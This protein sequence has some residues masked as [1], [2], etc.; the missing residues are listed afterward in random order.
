MQIRFGIFA[1]GLLALSALMMA[2]QSAHA[3]AKAVVE[4]FTSQGCSSCPPADKLAG[5]LA[6]DNDLIVLTLPVDYW[7]YLGWKDTLANGKFSARQKAYA[8]SRGDTAIYTPQMVVNGR[9]HVIGSDKNAVEISVTRQI[10]RFHGLPV[11]VTMTTKDDAIV[12]DVAGA[13]DAPDTATVW[14][15]TLD[16]TRSVEIKRGENRGLTATYFNVVHELQPVG[17]WKGRAERF[18]LPRNEILD[19]DSN[20]GCAVIVQI[21]RRGLPGAIVGAAMLRD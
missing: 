19:A 13:D 14:L 4:L 20:K 10:N 1:S 12:I 6:E 11:A 16:K 17:M 7:D 15:A 21:D 2:Q 9:E 18:E 5:K 8:Q 3:A